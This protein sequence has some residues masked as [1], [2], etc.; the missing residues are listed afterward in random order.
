MSI[1][2]LGHP[3]VS[4][5]G[6]PLRFRIKK[7]LALL[8][9]LAAEGGSHPRRWLAELLWPQSDERH[10]RTALRSALANLRK[11]LGED[12]AHDEEEVQEDRF[13]LAN[14][15]L[16]GVEPRGINLDLRTLESAVELARS[17]ASGTSPGGSRVEGAVRRRDLI[18]HLEE[19]LGVY[20]G[21]FME[22]FSLEDAHD[23]ELWLEAEQERWRGVFGEL[24][25][26]LYSLQVEAGE[27]R[28]AIDTVRL[29]TRHA[30][31]DEAPYRRLVELLSVAGDSTGALLA[32][33]D[34]RNTLKRRLGLEPSPQMRELAERLQEEVEERASLGPS[35]PRSET[36]PTPL[37]ALEVPFAGR[38]EEFGALVS[39]Y[40]AAC[41]GDRA[42]KTRV[43]AVL[44]EAG[45]GK[46]RLAN[47]F[48]GWARARGADVLKGG[49][50]EGAG[51][52]YGPLVEAIRPRIERERAP[53]DLLEDAWLAELS[54]LLPELKDRYSDL[55]SPT[56]GDGETAKGALFEAIARTVGALASRAP[57][58]L[59]LDDLQWVDATTLEVLDYAGSRWAEQGASALVLVAARPEES[60]EGRAGFERWLSSL[61]RRLPVKSLAL[62]PLGNEDVGGLLRRLARAESTSPAWPPEQPGGSNGTQTEPE[63][64]VERLLA[65][66]GGQPFYLVET[67]KAL[68]EDGKLVIRAR[69][70]GETVVEVGPDWRE[71]STLR[72]LLPQSVREVIHAR[73]SRLSATA[74]ELLRAGAVLERGFGFE[75]VARM[76]GLGEAEGLRGLE[77][78]IERRL[79]LEEAG[80][81]EEGEEPLF[82]TDTTYSFSHEKIR[83]VA[84]TE[85]GRAR[86]RVLHRRAFEVLEE[87][88]APAAQ[89]ARHALAGGLAEQAFGYSVAAGDQAVE[90]FAARDALEHYQRAHSL[91][92]EEVSTGGGQPIEPS[93]ADLEHLYTQLGRAYEMAD[94]WE[95]AQAAYETMRAL[96]RQ[97][98]E[99][100]LEV[101][102]LNLLAILT[103][104]QQDTDPPT[105]RRLLE[106]ARRVAEEA[107][108]KEALVETECNL[109]DVMSYWTGEHEHS[110][111]LARKTLASARA[112]EEERPDLIARAL[113][114]LARL[115]LIWGSLEES[116]AYAEEGAA[117]SRELVKR[118]PPRRMLLPSMGPAAT[119]F[120]ASWRAGT[121]ALEIQC[122]RILAYDRILQGRLREGIQ[123]AREV[124]GMSREL[125]ERAEALGSW[126]LGL[127]LSE[128]GEYEEAL[129]FCR[130]GTELARKLPNPFLLWLNLDHLGWA[131][132]AMLA[133]EEA[134]K[135]HEEALN[136]RGALGPQCERS[137]SI[138]LCVV[139]T[140]SENW[141]D[142]YAH[143]KRAHQGRTSLDV[144]GSLS[145]HYEVEALLRGGDERSA[146]EEV[147]QLAERGEVN[148]RE[149]VAYLRS[150]A[151]LSE[152]EGDTQRAIKHLYEAL[153]LAEKIRLPGELW[154]IQSKIGELHERRG[155]AEQA[156]E[157]F[158]GAAQ[159]LRM[160]AQKIEDEELRERFLSAPRVRRVLGRN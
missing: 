159:T 147:R 122:L 144:L 102:S 139:A 46:T 56:S 148:E 146:R 68:L 136:L 39:E 143:A 145:L 83:Q 66:T 87:G 1:S 44:G 77:E 20:Q 3:E 128:I 82:Y 109:A 140:L 37:S 118:R 129:E 81:G 25:Q 69:A 12:R 93:T 14:G 47:E 30:P 125:H 64:F 96:G 23:F 156:R 40:H 110:A 58:V 113:W 60:E 45:I 34:F 84:Y 133:F 18:A 48:L 120:L 127:G 100:R 75:S 131:Y 111:P 67:L 8:C 26:R 10:A 101:I 28:K 130:R 62:S 6:R 153:T 158:S 142:A 16:L 116:A 43:V 35:V 57:V 15:D 117:L 13:L 27:T 21:E 98:G 78:L 65:E 157:A 24:C 91:L 53:D 86:R 4:F 108:L 135:I 155:E 70:D 160:L 76:A 90:V 49:A 55:P 54:R 149:G 107:G 115:E 17:E 94:E 51:L 150:L 132:E 151:V 104:H 124:L 7:A 32:Y 9:Y 71:G 114:T 152:F 126:V 33:E 11:T 137:S 50:S 63:R 112:L 106:E 92:E 85:G 73:L 59:F 36:T 42:G 88:R 52:P 121:K 105:V 141:E 2:L 19:T 119:G 80:G 154:Q 79:L 74:S 138:R 97:L 61:R 134:R 41:A 89:L 99:A 95:K 31:L 103:F 72:G 123:M 29:W 38:Q 5:E 22:G